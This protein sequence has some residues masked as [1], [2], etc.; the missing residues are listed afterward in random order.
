MLQTY[1]HPVLQT[2]FDQDDR[3]L[4]FTSSYSK[5]LTVTLLLNLDEE[6]SKLSAMYFFYETLQRCTSLVLNR[7]HFLYSRSYNDT[8]RGS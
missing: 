6:K 8:Q 7:V 5:D 4:F 1:F 3:C 2:Q